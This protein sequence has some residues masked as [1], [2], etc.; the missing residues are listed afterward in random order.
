MEVILDMPMLMTYLLNMNKGSSKKQPI[1]R[2]NDN[3][4]EILKVSSIE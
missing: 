3:K 2:L 4:V 1:D